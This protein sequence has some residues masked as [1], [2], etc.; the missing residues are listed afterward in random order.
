[1][2]IFT[3]LCIFTLQLKMSMKLRQLSLLLFIL[4]VSGLVVTLI[5]HF[6]WS[7]DTVSLSN[8]TSSNYVNQVTSA[9]QITGRD[10]NEFAPNISATSSKV[11][12]PSSTGSEWN[13]GTITTFAATTAVVSSFVVLCVACILISAGVITMPTR[14]PVPAVHQG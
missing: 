7:V 4:I 5:S 3:S 14:A 2:I 6:L 11:S 10:L 12:F 13:T 8:V 1:M 9:N